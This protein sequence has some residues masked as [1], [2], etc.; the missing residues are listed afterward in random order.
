MT[1]GSYKVGRGRPPIETRWQPGQS[2]NPNGSS[3]SRRS[4]FAEDVA[5]VLGQPLRGITAGREVEI[6]VSTA[7]FRKLVNKAIRGDTKSMVHVLKLIPDL[8]RLNA[9]IKIHSPSDHD[10][11]RRILQHA[12]RTPEEHEMAFRYYRESLSKPKKRQRQ[13]A[14]ES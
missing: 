8:D 4:S 6:D 1:A 3:K 10:L 11:V 14:K 5:E 9:E 12:T 7:M 13:A 2:G